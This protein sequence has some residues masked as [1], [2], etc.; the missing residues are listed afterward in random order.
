MD[1]KHSAGILEFVNE[2]GLRGLSEDKLLHGFS[3]R[4]RSA[5][6]PVAR[7]NVIIDT[8]HPVHEGRVFRWRCDGSDFSPVSEYGRISDG[9]D[10]AQKWASS[11]F[12]HLLTSGKGELRRRLARGEATEFPILGELEAEGQTDYIALIHRFAEGAL[13][14]MDAVHS[15]WTTETPEGFTDAQL[16]ALR[17]L[18][19]AFALALKCVSLTRVAQ[20]LVTTYLG[21]DAGQRVLSG[22]VARG[23]ADRISAVLWYSDLRGFTRITET[24]EPHEVI[25][26]LNDYADAIISSVHDS[27]GDVLKLIGD[28]TLA[29]FK[30]DDPGAACAAALSAE[31]LMRARS[32]GVSAR[33]QARGLPV[34][35]AYLGLHIGEVFYGNVGSEDRLDFTVVG[36]A[37]NEVSRISVLC[38]SVEKDVLISSA[39]ATASRPEH[40]ARFVSVGRYALKGVERSQDLFTLERA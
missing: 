21:R 11:P 18:L 9:G 12:N 5:G 26:F 22:R 17:Q 4:L 19:P 2:A 27:G 29:I 8:L 15:S 20:T 30:A 33:R 1:L 32:S 14:E 38:R 25:P 7:A 28:G 40:R 3:E 10:A 24:A 13:G 35:D 31:K 23:V 36:P 39:F 34:T 6:I 37:V 16:A